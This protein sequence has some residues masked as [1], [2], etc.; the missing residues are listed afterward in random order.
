MVFNGDWHKGAS[1][2]K[3]EVNWSYH[4][5]GQGKGRIENVGGEKQK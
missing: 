4:L 5:G 2:N 3:F 1:K